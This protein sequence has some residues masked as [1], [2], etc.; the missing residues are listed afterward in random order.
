MV[1]HVDMT[2]N[3]SSYYYYEVIFLE[4]VLFITVKVK[5]AER[6]E[7]RS[8]AVFT[9]RP[10]RLTLSLTNMFLLFQSLDSCLQPVRCSF[11]PVAFYRMSLEHFFCQTY[12][13]F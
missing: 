8:H 4:Y 3:F 2:V 9:K 7:L 5:S 12:V 11:I 6:D 13:V 1:L 10:D